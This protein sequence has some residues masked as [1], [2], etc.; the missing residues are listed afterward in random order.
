MKSFCGF[1]KGLGSTFGRK[2]TQQVSKIDTN[3]AP[4]GTKSNQKHALAIDI[5][6]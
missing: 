4:K 3:I 1:W 5:V 2:I 6:F